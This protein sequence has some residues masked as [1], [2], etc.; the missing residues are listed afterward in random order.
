MAPESGLGVVRQTMLRR[1]LEVLLPAYTLGLLI[2]WLHREYMPAVFGES[3]NESLLAWLAWA[4]VGGLTGILVLWALI[5]AFFLCYS[6]LYLLGKTSILLGGGA[7]VD[8]R[9]FQFYVS[10]FLLLCLLAFVGYWDP[11]SAVMVFVGMAGCGPVFWRF[12]V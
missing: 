10:C 5:V 12:V 1:W 2:V 6:P 7:W 4:L 8:R 11:W 3:M 9:E